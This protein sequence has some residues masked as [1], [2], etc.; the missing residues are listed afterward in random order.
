MLAFTGSLHMRLLLTAMAPT[1]LLGLI[2]VSWLTHAR[3]DDVERELRETGQLIAEQ[4]AP[5]AE[6]GVISGN[7]ATLDALLTGSMSSPHV[8]SIEVLD[9]FGQR[10]IHIQNSEQPARDIQIFMAD[11]M[12]QSIVLDSELFL[13]DAPV[14]RSHE[15]HR[16][17]GQVRVGLTP[18]LFQQRQRQILLTTLILAALVLVGAAALAYAMTRSISRPLTRMSNSVQSLR[19]GELDTRLELSEAGDM[20]RLM[21]NINALAHS[22]Q[23]SQQQQQQAIGQLTT[24]REQAEAASRAKSDFLAMMSHELRT[25]MNGVMGMLQLLQTTELSSEQAEYVNVASE[26]TDHL[27]RVINDILDFS[28]IERG[29]I[30]LEMLDFDLPRL[31]G[32]TVASFEHAARQK[33]LTLRLNLHNE[34][35]LQLANGDATRIRQILVNLLGNA[36]KFTEGGEISVNA[37]ITRDSPGKFWLQCEV[38]DTGIGIPPEKLDSMFEAFKQADSSTSRRYGGTGLGLSIARTFAR[39]MGGEL[40]AS[41]RP[42]E[43][44]CFSLG[45]PLQPASATEHPVQS[46]TPGQLANASPFLLVEDN[47]VNQLVIQGLLRD[48]ENPLEVAGTATEALNLLMDAAPGHFALILMDLQLPDDDGLSVWQR[49]QSHC[50]QQGVTPPP[51][52]ALTASALDSERRQCLDAGMSGFV[53]KPVSRQKL[54]TEVHRILGSD[55]NAQA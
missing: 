13:L 27:L 29:I 24:A 12:R 18:S 1:V 47:P 30:E 45:I 53:S 49:Y 35:N 15:Q 44:S 26:S 8:H 34:A 36:L 39:H 23:L 5:A 37:L 40:Q 41:S 3:I 51:C 52:L 28:R 22:L 42:G 16:Y 19:D 38:R 31:L 17:L 14:S 10:L 54:L 21:D 33:G 4:L 48:L 55:R 9:R 2:L 11:I 7:R 32:S 6:Y 43:G 25:P 20:G 46:G 50:R